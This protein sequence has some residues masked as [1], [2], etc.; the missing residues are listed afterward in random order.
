VARAP[1]PVEVLTPEGQVFAGEVQADLVRHLRQWKPY[2]ER[3]GLLV[4]EL[5][6]LPTEL[7]A[8]NP[9]RTAAMADEATHGFSEQFLVE[10]GVFLDCAKK[11]GLDRHPRFQAQ[12]PSSDIGTVSL[13]FFTV[14]HGS[15]A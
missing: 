15:K 8:A 13:S 6:S 2:V 9:N 1:F 5:H 7:A 12:F 14:P 3:F 11:A 4:L 10:C